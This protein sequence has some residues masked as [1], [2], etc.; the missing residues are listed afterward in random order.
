MNVLPQPN[1]CE[2]FEFAMF[3]LSILALPDAHPVCLDE[4]PW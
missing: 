2:Q 3:D 4:A 1:R